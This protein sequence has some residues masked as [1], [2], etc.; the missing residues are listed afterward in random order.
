MTAVLA[1]Q[2]LLFVGGLALGLAAAWGRGPAKPAGNPE[3]RRPLG[4]RTVTV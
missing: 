1:K 2:S 4:D 3:D